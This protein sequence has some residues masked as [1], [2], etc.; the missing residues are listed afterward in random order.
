MDLTD[1]LGIDLIVHIIML[2]ASDL[3]VGVVAGLDTP[4]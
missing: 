1:P 3:G 2:E 4:G